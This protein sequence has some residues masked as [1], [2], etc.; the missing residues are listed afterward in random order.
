MY[1]GN[2]RGRSKYTI[3]GNWLRTRAMSRGHESGT[4]WAT[5]TLSEIP[6]S[7]HSLTFLWLLWWDLWD[8]SDL[9]PC[10]WPLS[11]PPSCCT[12]HPLDSRPVF[13]F[14]RSQCVCMKDSNSESVCLPLPG[15]MMMLVCF[16]GKSLW[17]LVLEQFEE[18]LVRILLLAACVSFVSTHHIG[19]AVLLRC[20]PYCSWSSCLPLSIFKGLYMCA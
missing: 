5:L 12:C 14:C 17:E 3:Q 19:C 20:W 9:H 18:L 6:D 8:C 13:E 7:I 10:R 2:N 1:W 15:W 11:L 4:G 16:L